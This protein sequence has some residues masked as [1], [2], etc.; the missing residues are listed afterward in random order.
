MPRERPAA[1]TGG[2]D[3]LRRPLATLT[4]AA[5]DLHGVLALAGLVLHDGVVGGGGLDKL[6]GGHDGSFVFTFTSASVPTSSVVGFPTDK[7]N[8]TLYKYCQL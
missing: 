6:D 8:N 7:H 2:D 4:A 3:D 1:V 5:D